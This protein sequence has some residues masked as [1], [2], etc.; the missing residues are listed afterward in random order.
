MVLLTALH[1]AARAFL[2]T[3][4]AL[5]FN[6]LAPIVSGHAVVTPRRAS[7]NRPDDLSEPEWTGLLRLVSEVQAAAEKAVGSS[8]SNLLLR[9]GG[10]AAFEGAPMHAHVVPRLPGDFTR[11]DDVF[12]AMEAW[13]PPGSTPSTKPA[14]ALDLPDDEQRRDRTLDEM[15]AE[16]ASYRAAAAGGAGSDLTCPAVSPAADAADAAGEA[17]EAD[18]PFGRF[19]IPAS[20]VFYDSPSRLTHAFVNLRPLVPG[21]V[22]VTP[23]RIV[24]RL[25]LLTQDER[26]DLWASVRVVRALVMATHAGVGSCELGVQ[27]GKVAGQSVPHVHVHVFPRPSSHIDS[28]L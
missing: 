20:I 4:H 1:D 25:S 12:G 11:N 24:D 28:S 21:H 2:A 18:R 27:D 9:E 22:L 10:C 17:A 26:D 14:A 8:A 13:A 23:R 3:T 5:A 15:Q 6:E 16:A 7:A 19:P